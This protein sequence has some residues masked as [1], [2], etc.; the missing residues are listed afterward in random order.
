MKLEDARKIA[1]AYITK[2]GHQYKRIEIVGSIR[3]GKHEVKDIDL[4]AIPKFPQEKQIIR[5]EVEGIK[6]EVY[7]AN[8]KNYEVLRLIRTG[9]A[10]HNIKLASMAIKKGCRLNFAEG[11][12]LKDGSS[13]KTEK[14]ILETLLGTYIDPKDREVS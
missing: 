11:L 4:V 6:V 1:E 9:S 5:T 12:I 10:Q 3:R 2:I 7:I 13:I 8:D 14:E